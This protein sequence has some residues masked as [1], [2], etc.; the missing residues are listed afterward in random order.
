MLYVIQ[1]GYNGVPMI[2]SENIVYCI[3]SVKKI[4]D[5]ELDFI[6][7]NGHAKSGL[8][9]FYEKDKIN[10]IGSILDFVAIKAI[11]WRD[12][13]DVKRRKEAEF[14]VL[15]DIPIS[16]ILGYAVYNENAKIKLEELGIFSNKIVIKPDYY[17]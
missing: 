4:L 2:P 13:L 7:T 5:L 9:N 17:F 1:N 3:S 14:L 16:G 15:N 8:S 10:E 12:D 6:F 11:W